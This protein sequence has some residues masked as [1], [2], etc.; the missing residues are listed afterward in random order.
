MAVFQHTTRL[1][2]QPEKEII[3]VD[4]VLHSVS[5]PPK[6][7]EVNSKN[8]SLD[9][10]VA[11]LLQ[12]IYSISRT[13]A[14]SISIGKAVDCAKDLQAFVDPGE[15][16]RFSHEAGYEAVQKVWKDAEELARLLDISLDKPSS[17]RLEPVYAEK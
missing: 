14:T 6:A 15:V 5:R 16:L 8:T 17:Y 3:M 2:R 1:S 12:S 10:R 13:A 4:P 9:S 11:E 7:V